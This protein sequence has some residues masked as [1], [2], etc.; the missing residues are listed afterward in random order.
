MPIK[1]M[2]FMDGSW[3]YRSRQSLFS[4]AGEEGFEFDY[5]KMVELLRKD[6]EERLDQDVDIVRTCYF[7]MLPANKLGY[8]PSKQ[9]VFYH[10]LA[11]QCGF[12]TDITQLDVH[13][14]SGVGDDRSVSVSLA[15]RAMH[16]AAIPGVF[17]I[18]VIIGG[19]HEYRAL[20]AGLHNLGK[21]TMVVA[22]RNREG[23]MVTSPA[24]ITEPGV[25]DL[26]IYFLEDHLADIRLVRTE[27]VRTC[28]ICGGQESTT[29]AG[30]DFFCSKCR[31]DH[32]RRVRVCDAC[33]K[34]EET[35]WNKD[36]FYCA[37]CRRNHR[38]MRYGDFSSNGQEEPE[39]ET[40]STEA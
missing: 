11:S 33:G 37:E 6:I 39:E 19:S 15:V 8:N 35:T 22:V 12:D 2:V 30:P 24:L 21:R 36:Y 23:Y 25:S 5:R 7:G 1:A 38:E 14:E 20:C 13:A 29:W 26:P 28:K 27:Q 34:E 17:D 4:N 3:F 40:P 31:N 10:F 9:R 32:R 16:F 18:A